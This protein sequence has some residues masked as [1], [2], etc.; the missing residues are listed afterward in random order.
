MKKIKIRSLS[1][2]SYIKIQKKWTGRMFI[3]QDKK[4][5]ITLQITAPG[6]HKITII[7]SPYLSSVSHTSEPYLMPR[8]KKSA[9]MSTGGRGPPPLDQ[10]F[11]DGMSHDAQWNWFYEMSYPQRAA[12]R[13]V[14]KTVLIW[15]WF[16]KP[17]F[18]PSCAPAS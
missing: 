13:W 5:L 7:R 2:Y 4:F 15:L 8:I 11:L 10:A 17:I 3:R 12:L 9:R 1:L 14:G 16:G 18:L 6:N